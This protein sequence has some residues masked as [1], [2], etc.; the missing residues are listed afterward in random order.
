VDL[1]IDKRELLDESRERNLTLGMIEKDYVL[2]WMLFGFGTI[3]GLTFK[4][5]TALSRYISLD[6]GVYQKTL[7]LYLNMI[8]RSL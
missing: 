1:L 4:G 5:G 2:G 8:S 7:I 6:F 3:K